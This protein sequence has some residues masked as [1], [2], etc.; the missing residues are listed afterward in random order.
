[1][2]KKEGGGRDTCLIRQAA[3][4][5]VGNVQQCAPPLCPCLSRAQTVTTCRRG[6]A[7]MELLLQDIGNGPHESS[8]EEIRP[9][10]SFPLRRSEGDSKNVRSWKACRLTE[11][12]ATKAYWLFLTHRNHAQQPS[13]TLDKR[14]TPGGGGLFSWP[15]LISLRAHPQPSWILHPSVPRPHSGLPR[16]EQAPSVARPQRRWHLLTGTGSQRW[17]RSFSESRSVYRTPVR[18]Q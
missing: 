11:L 6:A 14:R 17:A 18:Q 10:R 13:C 5:L 7:W 2:R 12:I 1:M 4:G 16:R 15:P 3:P 8:D 9:P